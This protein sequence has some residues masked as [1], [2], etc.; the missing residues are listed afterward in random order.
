MKYPIVLLCGVLLAFGCG[1]SGGGDVRNSP[2]TLAETATA[3][4]PSAPLGPNLM[5]VYATPV[6]YTEGDGQPGECA[7]SNDPNNP[8]HCT[9]DMPVPPAFRVASAWYTPFH[10]VPALAAFHYLD[11]SVKSDTQVDLAAGRT[12]GGRGRLRVKIYAL[13]VPR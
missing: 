4:A 2:S 10:G 12:P 6:V 1:T 5:V 13:C 7:A 3:V 9:I 11:V 8:N